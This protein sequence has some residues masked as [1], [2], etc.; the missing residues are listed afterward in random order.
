MKERTTNQKHLVNTIGLL[1][2]SLTVW[3]CLPLLFSDDDDGGDWEE[4]WD[5]PT[6]T[7]WDETWIVTNLFDGQTAVPLNHM[8]RLSLGHRDFLDLP[9]DPVTEETRQRAENALSL[10]QVY[11]ANNPSSEIH[12]ELTINKNHTLIRHGTF[13]EDTDYVLDVDRVESHLVVNRIIP[14]ALRF[15]TAR[16]PQVTGIWRNEKT[17]IVSFSEPIDE[18]TLTLSHQS[19]D[20]LWEADNDI[21]SISSSLNLADFTWATE[22]HLFMLAPLGFVTSGW[23]KITGDV[24]AISGAY[25]DGNNNG[26]PGETDD[27]YVEEI[28]FN[29]LPICYARE[30]IP[31]PCIAD[32]EIDYFSL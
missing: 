14:D 20:V 29:Y 3:G 17:L 22:G 15:S 27:D 13:D 16:R 12:L 18:N 28:M 26:I 2:V 25:L 24:R 9:D 10:I 31:D 32:E 21:S 8:I 6:A 19:F 23:I 5:E 30:D 1:C 4:D 7:T 11:E